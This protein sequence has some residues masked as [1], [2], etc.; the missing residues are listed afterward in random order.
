MCITFQRRLIVAEGCIPKEIYTHLKNVHKVK[1]SSHIWKWIAN[2]K[3]VNRR[4]LLI[5]NLLRSGCPKLWWLTTMFRGSTSWFVKSEGL[6]SMNLSVS[7]VFRKKGWTTSS[8]MSWI[9]EKFVRDRSRA[10][11]PDLRIYLYKYG[12]LGVVRKLLTEFQK[13]RLFQFFVRIFP[14]FV[15]FYFLSLNF[16]IISQT[17]IFL[18]LFLLYKINLKFSQNLVN[19]SLEFF[20]KFL[21]ITSIHKLY[22]KFTLFF[23][24]LCIDT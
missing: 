5:S 4:L 17:F 7:G 18:P 8:R 20:F 11:L 2:V 19:V 10:V 14:F 12:F 6:H 13:I 21:K 3:K 16:P 9:F 15:N 23:Y 22:K 1:Q 24:K